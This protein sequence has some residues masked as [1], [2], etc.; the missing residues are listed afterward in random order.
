MFCFYQNDSYIAIW[1]VVI[2]WW[3]VPNNRTPASRLPLSQPQL[4]SFLCKSS[5]YFRSFCWK[6]FLKAFPCTPS[7]LVIYCSKL[8]AATYFM[9]EQ[10]IF[11]R[12]PTGQKWAPS[13]NIWMKGIKFTLMVECS[14]SWS[15]PSTTVCSIRNS[16]L[17][18]STVLGSAH[19][20]L[21]S[22]NEIVSAA[23]KCFRDYSR[24]ACF[25]AH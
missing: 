14:A 8:W 16:S 18:C 23:D 17:L 22:T 6:F 4:I 21:K 15:Q 2:W 9:C 24:S 3:I 19:S 7:L 5:G 13:V 11:P 20:R 1:L 25:C 12:N 10:T